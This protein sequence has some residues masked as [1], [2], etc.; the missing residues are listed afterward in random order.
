MAFN[1]VAE[2]AVP[3]TYFAPQPIAAVGG[4]LTIFFQ[5]ILIASGNL[6]WLNWL[7]VVLVS[8]CPLW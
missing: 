7:T 1:H 5:S 4:V 2:I 8:L 6:S 3:F